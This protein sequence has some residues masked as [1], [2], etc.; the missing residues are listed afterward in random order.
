MSEKNNTFNL[1]ING[2]IILILT[3]LAHNNGIAYIAAL[4]VIPALISRL[5]CVHGVLAAVLTA[6]AALVFQFVSAITT[7]NENFL[8]NSCLSL[9]VVLPGFVIGYC[10]KNKKPF[11][12]MLVISAGIDFIF[13]L[14]ALLAMKYFANIN[15][16]SEIRSVFSDTFTEYFEI[17][18]SVYPE[19][20]LQFAQ[21]ENELYNTLYIAVPGLLPFSVFAVS[22]LMFLIKYAVSKNLCASYLVESGNFISGFDTFSLGL[23]T[24][25]AFAFFVVCFIM[26]TSNMWLM[27]FLNAV[28]FVLLLYI[29]VT[30]SIVDFKLK[31]RIRSPFKRYCA[32]FSMAVLSII[33]TAFI[34]II[35]PIYVFI[36]IGVLDSFVDFRKLR[37]KKR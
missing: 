28:L 36:I 14:A 31:E 5:L 19:A 34:P 1:I 3:V 23:V 20:G 32:L 6:T 22:V 9:A 2:V 18:A 13:L 21:M 37:T 27:I 17:I 4:F 10:F 26:S 25:I 15:L 35:N 11:S 29:I 24:S 30:I 7:G 8:F 12:D 16:T 33:I